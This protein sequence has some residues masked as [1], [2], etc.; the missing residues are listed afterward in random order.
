MCQ[1]HTGAY[2][3]LLAPGKTDDTA[4]HPRTTTTCIS[5]VVPI[6]THTH[7]TR[8]SNGKKKQRKEKEIKELTPPECA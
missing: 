5:H 3:S 2:I 6:T 1:V 4:C 7:D 8:K